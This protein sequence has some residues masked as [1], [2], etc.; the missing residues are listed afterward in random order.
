MDIFEEDV[1]DVY[2]TRI[3]GADR[4]IDVEVTLI[5]DDGG[6]L[7]GLLVWFSFSCNGV[8][9]GGAETYSV[10]DQHILIGDV[11]NVAVTSSRASPCLE[12]STVLSILKSNVL[13]VSIRDVI[14]HA[15]VLAD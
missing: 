13:Q 2:L 14:F 7:T 5:E 12:S 10:L 11:V 15:C 6:V 1:G 9:R 4:F 3:G 8:E